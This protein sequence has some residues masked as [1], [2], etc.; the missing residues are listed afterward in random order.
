MFVQYT[1][2]WYHYNKRRSAEEKDACSLLLSLWASVML[3]KARGEFRIA[4]YKVQHDIRLQH[5][6]PKNYIKMENENQVKSIFAF[7][8]V[9][10]KRKRTRYSFIYAHMHAIPIY[11]V[12]G[13]R[14]PAWQ[15]PWRKYSLVLVALSIHENRFMW[16][17]IKERNRIIWN[18]EC[19]WAF[20]NALH[21]CQ[22]NGVNH[23]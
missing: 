15:Q 23:Q 20:A 2:Q 10:G 7:L 6:K 17:T 12:W 21:L 8:K 9:Y 16:M 5:T 14:I 22:R 18:P 1:V 11:K 3:N 13:W 4:V 19:W